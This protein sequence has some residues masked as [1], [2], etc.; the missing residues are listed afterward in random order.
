MLLNSSLL[1]DA[2]TEE[3]KIVPSVQKA[4]SFF[5]QVKR[6]MLLV[7]YIKATILRRFIYHRWF[8]KIKF[9]L[10]DEFSFRFKC[11]PLV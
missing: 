11:D 1:I 5:F 4:I 10:E 7:N 8:N 6:V 9:H 3:G 2:K